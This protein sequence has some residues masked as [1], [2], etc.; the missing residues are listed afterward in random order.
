MIVITYEIRRRLFTKM[1]DAQD[2]MSETDKYNIEGESFGTFLKRHGLVPP[3]MNS[4]EYD[5]DF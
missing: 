2:I 1:K 5:E 3:D 4:P